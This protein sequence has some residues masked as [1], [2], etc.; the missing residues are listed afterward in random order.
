MAVYDAQSNYFTK[1]SF[2]TFSMFF[3]LSTDLKIV[4]RSHSAKLAD[5]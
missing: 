1:F 4:E 3:L 2:Y 5:F